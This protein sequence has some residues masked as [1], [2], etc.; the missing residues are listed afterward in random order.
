MQRRVYFALVL[1]GI[2]FTA[3]A[4][5]AANVDIDVKV[6]KGKVI[7]GAGVVKLARGDH[8]S[9]RVASD[10]PEKLHIHGYDLHLD[11]AADRPAKLDFDADRTGR[12]AV[13][14][15]ASDL[16][17]VVLEIYPK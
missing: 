17:L 3:C 7:S 2:C 4:A 14:F 9:L 5:W 12:F 13:E 1:A 8:V 6:Q 11:V 10:R 16:Q 15:H